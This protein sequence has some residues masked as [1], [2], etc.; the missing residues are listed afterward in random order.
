MRV[1]CGDYA[2]FRHWCPFVCWLDSRL[3]ASRGS[4]VMSHLRPVLALCLWLPLVA[5]S[6]AA[7]KGVRVYGPKVIS[8]DTPLPDGC[9]GRRQETDTM[10]A[11]DPRQPR[12]LVATWDQ[13]GH[14]SNVVATSRNGGRSWRLSTL[15]GISKCTGGTSDQ[16][17]DP[18]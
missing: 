13:D 14:R 6:P 16:V 3:R 18:W 7:A 11:A 9:D 5:T 4:S 17:V 15:P 12:H 8:R 1:D 10:I 2:G